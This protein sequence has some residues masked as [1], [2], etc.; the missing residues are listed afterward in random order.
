MANRIFSIIGWVGTALVF[1]SLALRFGMPAQDQY[2]YYLALGGLACMLVYM[3]S[4]WRDI[5]AFFGRRQARYGTLAASSVLIVLGIL[6]AVNYIGAR[7]N[8][9]WDLTAAKQFSLSDQSRNVLAKLDSPLQLMVFTQNTEFQ[10]FQDR[11]REYEYSS[12]QVTTEYIDPDQKQSIAKQYEVQQYGTIVINYKGRTER[13]T[14]NTEQDI[15]NG[16]IKVVSGEQRKV[17]FTEGHGEKDVTSSEREG[18]SGISEALKRE[19]YAVEKTVLAQQGAVPEDASMVV[20]AGPKNDFL[21]PEVDALKKYLDKQGKLLLMLDPP[22][23]PDDKP[24]PNLVALAHDWGIDVGADLIVD[25]SG[26]GK[27]FGANE[28][29][30]VAA[31][32]PSHPITDRFNVMTVFPLSRSVTPVSGGVSGHTAQP[33]VQ[34]SDR[35]WAEA[36]LKSVFGQQ[37][38]SMDPKDGD[39][40]G[41][42][43]VAAAVSAAAPA[44]PA[45]PTKPD[46]NLNAPK[47]ETRVAVYG[48]SDFPANSYLG[49]AGNRDLFMNTIGWLSQ[50]ENLIAIRPKEADDRRLTMTATQQNN[51]VW[52][53]LFIIPGLVIATG[54]YNWFRRR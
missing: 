10:P 48:D 12:K 11:L 23:G 45:D 18:F 8:K 32:Y 13:V 35:S 27:L 50:Q 46:P 21:A 36:N 28:G 34:T 31:G 52:L 30:P 44:P 1:A 26:M 43:T 42:I 22:D 38:V 41:P 20:I 39:K 14:S 17:Y 7:Q 16:I 5:A 29:M 53:S 51:L 15:T 9:R 47:P 49:F 40:P 24:L 4:Q 3:A 6:V 54:V 33:V 19:N 2:A 37:G 25:I